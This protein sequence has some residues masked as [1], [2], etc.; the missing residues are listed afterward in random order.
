MLKNPTFRGR[1]GGGGG[2]R[3]NQEQKGGGGGGGGGFPEK[4]MTKTEREVGQFPD[5][6][7]A[8]QKRG[9]GLDTLMRT[10]N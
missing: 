8:C 1:G 5:L 7:G 9:E 10:M 2:A 3:E 4:P 6:R